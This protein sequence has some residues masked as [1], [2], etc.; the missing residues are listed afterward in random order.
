MAVSVVDVTNRGQSTEGRNRRKS[1]TF[2]SRNSNLLYVDDS[3]QISFGDAQNH[4]QGGLSE[5]VFFSFNNLH[6]I[7]G[8]AKMEVEDRKAHRDRVL[9]SRIISASLSQPGQGTQLAEPVKITFRHLSENMTDAVCVYWDV[10]EHSWSS[11]G[12]RVKS[13]N[14]TQTVCECDHLTNFAV[15]MRPLIPGDES[16]V[17]LESILNRIDIIGS[18]VAAIFVFCLVLILLVV[19]H[20]IL[21]FYFLPFS[22]LAKNGIYRIIKGPLGLR[23]H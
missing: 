5:V 20:D 4:A 6:E 7:L 11:Q 17:L 12:C 3:V 19:R 1:L 8:H 18:V 16:E 13:S 10:D 14:R 9:N 15:S 2:P 23:S 21:L 22:G